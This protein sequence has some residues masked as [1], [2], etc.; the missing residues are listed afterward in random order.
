MVLETFVLVWRVGRCRV[1]GLGSRFRF[2]GFGIKAWGF[3]AVGFKNLGCRLGVLGAQTL[4]HPSS[5]ECLR[6]QEDPHNMICG[7]TP[8]CL[9][10]LGVM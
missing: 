4:Q 1:W 8:W 7:Y 6:P 2:W 3:W 9:E 10:S 5:T